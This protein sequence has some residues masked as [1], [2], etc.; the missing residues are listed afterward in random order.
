MKRLIII[1]LLSHLMIVSNNGY[2]QTEFRLF[3]EQL[4]YLD[5]IHYIELTNKS[6][7]VREE[8]LTKNGFKL[9]TIY[10]RRIFKKR[11]LITILEILNSKHFKNLET[12]YIDSA[13]DG[14]RTEYKLTLDQ[15][16]QNI[17]I[18]NQSVEILKKLNTE[19]NR[20]IKKRK[21]RI[22]FQI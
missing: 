17:I 14:F 10:K 22:L 21:A 3:I 5:G 18:E 6:I 16:I 2:G 8:R 13:I 19:I 20:L 12:E 15:G 4:N 1:A 11:K 9:N 7:L